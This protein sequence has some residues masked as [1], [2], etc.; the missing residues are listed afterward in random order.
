MKLR[1]IK[2]CFYQDGKGENT[3]D[4]AFTKG[5]IYELHEKGFVYDDD[6]MVNWIYEADDENFVEDHFE[7]VNV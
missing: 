3:G 5:K 7:E 4:Q 1:C 2:D 6:G